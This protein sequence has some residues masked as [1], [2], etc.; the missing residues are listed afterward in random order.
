MKKRFRSKIGMVVLLPCLLVVALPFIVVPFSWFTL[1][2]TAFILLIVLPP[3]LGTY[4]WIDDNRLLIRS[5]FIFK[6]DIDI[7]SIVA[8]RK[9]NN[10]SSSPALSLDRIEV[11]YDGGNRSVIISPAKRTD[12]I[13]SIKKVNKAIQLQGKFLSA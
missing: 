10:P 13:D 6:W 7:S 5:A 4:Y 12:F 9:T 3:F 11:I 8:V 1:A 2:L